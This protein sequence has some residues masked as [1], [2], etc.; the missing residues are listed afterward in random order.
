MRTR[1]YKSWITIVV[2]FISEWFRAQMCLLWQA[3][4]LWCIT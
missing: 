1:F 4:L 3:Q 2:V